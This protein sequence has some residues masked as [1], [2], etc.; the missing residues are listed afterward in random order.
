MSPRR[1]V[2]IVSHGPSCLDGVMAAAVVVTCPVLLLYFCLQRYFVGGL[3][4]GGLK[5]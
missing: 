2:Q 3:T 1:T 5:E 4:A